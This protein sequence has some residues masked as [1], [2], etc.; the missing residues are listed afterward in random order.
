V[1]ATTITV[2]EDRPFAASRVNRTGGYIDGVLICGTTSRNGRDYPLPVLKRDYSRYEGAAV[3]CDHKEEA[4]VERRIGWFSDVRPG[5][6]GKPRG[7]LHLLKSHPMTERVFEAAERNPALFGMSHV[8]VCSTSRVNG[9]ETVEGINKVVSID[10]VADPATTSSLYES[11]IRRVLKEIADATDTLPPRDDTA[12]SVL[13]D[14][15]RQLSND[16]ESKAITVDAFEEQVNELIK[17]YRKAVAAMPP[18]GEGVIP[19]DGKAFAERLKNPTPWA[20]DVALVDG[21]TYA[22]WLKSDTN[23]TLAEFTANH[24][25]GVIP[26]DGKAF[27]ER[28]LGG[29]PK[30]SD[31][32]YRKFLNDIRGH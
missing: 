12:V 29:G 3:N 32:E 2:R 5:S 20:A 30:L 19:T 10:L 22:Q 14:R 26:T 24:K 17:S 7:R 28:Y 13:L 4:T 18:T 1:S 9:R 25:A 16:F 27:A 6:D 21:L 31:A 11:T 23:Q 8:A 15:V